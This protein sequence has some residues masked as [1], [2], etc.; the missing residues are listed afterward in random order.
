VYSS[1]GI[2]NVGNVTPLWLTGRPVVPLL[3][4]TLCILA[5]PSLGDQDTVLPM[6]GL[7]SVSPRVLKLFF[8][9]SLDLFA[10]SVWVG[11]E[12]VSHWACWLMPIIP[13]T[14]EAK[15]EGSWSEAGPGRSTRT[16]LKKQTKSK[17]TVAWLNLCKAST[18]PWVQSPVPPKKKSHS[19]SKQWDRTEVIHRRFNNWQ[20]LTPQLSPS[21][22]H[23]LIPNPPC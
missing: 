7:N 12:I 5:K 8:K 21:L 10:S 4:N 3:F 16:N 23:L 22:H 2:T 11:F 6:W 20:Y 1:Q 18:R 9:V 15:V 17:R 13:A 14:Q 19:N